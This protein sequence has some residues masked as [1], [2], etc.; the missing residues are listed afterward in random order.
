MPNNRT[1]KAIAGYHLLM[2]LSAVDFR[3]NVAKDLVIR[4]YLVHEFPIHVNLDRQMEVISRLR[5]EEWEMHFLKMMDDFYDDA[6]DSE[7][8]NLI[9]FAIV[10]TKADEVI[11]VEEN[12][13]LNLLFDH[14]EAA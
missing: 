9:N 6:T 3:I 1:N 11:T 8:K 7:R 14:W 13:Y 4:E 12:H 10:L 2:I 5:P